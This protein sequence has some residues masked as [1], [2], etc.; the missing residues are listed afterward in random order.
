M[1][2]CSRPVTSHSSQL[3]ARGLCLFYVPSTSIPMLGFAYDI[4]WLFLCRRLSLGSLMVYWKQNTETALSCTKTAHCNVQSFQFHLNMNTCDWHLCIN[5]LGFLGFYSLLNRKL[6]CFYCALKQSENLCSSNVYPRYPSIRD[7]N[8]AYWTFMKVKKE[9]ACYYSV[10]YLILYN[11]KAYVV[12]V[13]V[14]VTYNCQNTVCTN[15]K[16]SLLHCINSSPVMSSL[17]FIND[18]YVNTKPKFDLWNSALES[19]LSS[20]QEQPKTSQSNNRV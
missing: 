10:G 4:S 12:W 1:A 15:R 2:L 17:E 19:P 18:K 6:S 3:T 9:M 11:A 8:K 7:D 14:C 16:Q 20:C 5:Q 13:R